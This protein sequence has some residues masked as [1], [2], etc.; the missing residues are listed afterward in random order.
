[1]EPEEIE[2]QKTIVQFYSMNCFPEKAKDL[3][4]NKECFSVPVLVFDEDYPTFCELGN[5]NFDTGKWSHFGDNSMKL[6]CWCF[7]P[8]PTDYIKNNKLYSVKH[9]GYRD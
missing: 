2:I 3:K 6:I 8:N 7:L 1:M 9:E 4:G 5:Y